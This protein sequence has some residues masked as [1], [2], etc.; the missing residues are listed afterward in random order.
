M[1]SPGLTAS[2]GRR[3]TRGERWGRAGAR[4]GLGGESETGLA[5]RA[6]LIV[7]QAAECHPKLCAAHLASCRW[8]DDARRGAGGGGEV[9]GVSQVWYSVI[10]RRRHARGWRWWGGIGCQSGVV[11][12]LSVHI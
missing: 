9:A 4:G 5:G 7:H 10:G 3:G 11:S 6:G 1:W 8:G 2:G 12:P